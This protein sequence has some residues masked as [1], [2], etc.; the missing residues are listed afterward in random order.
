MNQNKV[1]VQI[2]EAKL[3]LKIYTKRSQIYLILKMCIR[4]GIH[5]TSY[6]NS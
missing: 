5:K 6:A 2:D 3:Y 4:V 1:F